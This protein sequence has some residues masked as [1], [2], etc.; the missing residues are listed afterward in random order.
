MPDNKGVFNANVNL[1]AIDDDASTSKDNNKSKDTLDSSDLDIPIEED[2]NQNSDDEDELSR[3]FDLLER[4]VDGAIFDEP[5]PDD[6]DNKVTSGDED[7]DIPSDPQKELENLKK[8]YESSSEEAKRIRKKLDELEAYEDFVPLLKVMREDPGLIRTVE[9][10]LESGGQADPQSVRK[11]LGVDEDFVFDYDE[12]I[13]DPSSPSAKVLERKVDQMVN[14]R[15]RE[16]N[17]L[18]DRQRLIQSQ[19]REL[20]EEFG[21]DESEV[22]ETLDWAKNHQLTLKDIYLLKNRDAR[23][24]KIV[25]KAVDARKRQASKMSQ[26]PKSL[27]HVGKSERKEISDEARLMMLMKKLSDGGD[28]FGP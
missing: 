21:I 17:A 20:I 15:L 11:E 23:D 12:A 18:S 13:N 5:L 27:A 9:Q 10:Y 22:E 4:D 26:T 3:Y 16:Q 19:R 1:D 25:D 14:S 24:K 28:I 8:R 6:T 2:F 7:S